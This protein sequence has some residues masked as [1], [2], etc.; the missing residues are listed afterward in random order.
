MKNNNFL[1]T[2]CGLL[3]FIILLYDGLIHSLSVKKIEK[4]KKCLEGRNN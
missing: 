1:K 3:S 2:A 4:Y